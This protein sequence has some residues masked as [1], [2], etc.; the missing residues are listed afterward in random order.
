MKQ[1]TKIYLG[2]AEI[3]LVF[4]A[5]AMGLWLLSDGEYSRTVC[6]VFSLVFM[7]AATNTVLTVIHLLRKDA[8]GSGQ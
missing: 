3:L 5:T 8:C 2:V 4:A 1:R 7:V 6:F